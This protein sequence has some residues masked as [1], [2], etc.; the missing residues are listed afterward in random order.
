MVSL[1][2]KESESFKNQVRRNEDVKDFL[3]NE[4]CNTGA[5]MANFN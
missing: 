3:H 2:M 4:Q 1:A 5:F